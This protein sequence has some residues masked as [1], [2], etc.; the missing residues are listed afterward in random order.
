MSELALQRHTIEARLAGIDHIDLVGGAA[1]LLDARD[2]A[3]A[4]QRR[5]GLTRLVALVEQI[6]REQLDTPAAVGAIEADAR[7]EED[8]AFLILFL[9]EV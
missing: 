4:L 8:I 1:E 7:V 3:A 6:L 9:I 5:V 2:R